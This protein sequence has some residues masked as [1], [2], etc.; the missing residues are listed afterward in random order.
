VPGPA[1]PCPDVHHVGVGIL[2]DYFAAASD[3]HAAAAI[4][5]AGGPGGAEPFSPDLAV[6]IRSGDRDAIRQLMRPKTRLSEH[7]VHALHVKGIN[8]LFNLDDLEALLTG[9]N[10]IVIRSRDRFC[11][12]IAVRDGGERLVLTLTDELQSALSRAS[13]QR[14]NAVSEPWSRTDG[15]GGAAEAD[16]L[17]NF[18]HEFARLGRIATDTNQRMYC[19][20]C[21]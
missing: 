8:P 14:L 7:G 1:W 4:D 17:A 6:A 9:V 5:L 13:E 19:W 10:T 21:V 20:L 2:Y 16:A 15:F 3:D 12:D 11:K 18:L